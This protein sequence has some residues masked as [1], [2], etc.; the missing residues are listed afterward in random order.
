[1]DRKVPK[2]SDPL[3]KVADL[4]RFNRELMFVLDVLIRAAAASAEIGTRRRHPMGRFFSNLDNLR[5][6]ELFLF[7]SNFRGNQFAVDG[8][9]NEDRFALVTGDSAPATGDV[10]ALKM[11]CAHGARIAKP[12]TAG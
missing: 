11:D 12:F 1:M 3:K 9:G 5:F 8:V 10:F 4:T 7:S 2:F 6:G